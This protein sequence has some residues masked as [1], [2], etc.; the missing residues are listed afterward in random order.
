MKLVVT[1][2]SG[3]IGRHVLLGV[4]R[5]WTVTAIYDST[6]LG[7]FIVDHA[8]G[9]VTPVRCDLTD[10][11]AVR[12]LANHVGRCD[13]ALYLAANGD[14]AAS[15]DR[16]GWDLRLNTVAVVNFLEQVMVDRMIYMSSGAVYDGVSGVVTPATPV[17][18]TLPYAIAKLASERYVA[19]FAARGR[20]PVGYVNVRF[21]GAYG[22]YEAPRKI[23]TRWLRSIIDGQRT[24]TIRGDGQNLID[25][26]YVDDAVN[27]L[28]RLMQDVSFNGTVDLASG[29]PVSIDAIAQ[30]MARAVGVEV[31]LCHEGRV[32]EYNNFRS[33]DR[34]MH[35]HFGFA[36]TIAFDDGIRR[37]S[38]HLMAECGLR[39]A[40]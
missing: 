21:F 26:M 16:P 1:G 23:T 20:L 6:D 36:P 27:A 29:T 8:L 5:D 3:F 38:S 30:S 19:F 13:V 9:H 22:P 14:P 10:T 32:P 24:F 17:N 12:E 2:A 34:T 33:V 35:E 40:E 31:T 7:P 4:P 28:L 11:F 25:F 39:T 37:L 15:A 18:P